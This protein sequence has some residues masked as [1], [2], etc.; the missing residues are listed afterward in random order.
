MNIVGVDGLTGSVTG[1]QRIIP[2]RGELL[3][4]VMLVYKVEGEVLYP[5]LG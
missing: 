3:R 1:K 5:G 2:A 4:L